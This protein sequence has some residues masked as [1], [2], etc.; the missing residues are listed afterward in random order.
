MMP[1]LRERDRAVDS[2]GFECSRP[3]IAGRE[4]SSSV[5]AKLIA[6]TQLRRVFFR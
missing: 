5:T 2:S 1:C 3:I 6:F 4:K